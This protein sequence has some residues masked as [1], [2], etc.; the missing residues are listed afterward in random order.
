MCSKCSQIIQW[1][2][3]WHIIGKYGWPDWFCIYVLLG[4]KSD[5]HFLKSSPSC[6]WGGRVFFGIESAGIYWHSCSWGMQL[7]A[8]RITIIFALVIFLWNSLANEGIQT[9]SSVVV[10]GYRVPV[11]SDDVKKEKMFS[12][13]MNGGKTYECELNKH[14]NWVM[15]IIMS[16]II[17]VQWYMF[18]GRWRSRPLY[19]KYTMCYSPKRQKT[20]D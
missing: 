4:R 7:S 19:Q 16:Y 9:R 3:A 6:V 2:L 8:G 20:D 18:K 14:V 15:I 10:Q 17:N 1:H 11:T 12:F 13:L 5:V